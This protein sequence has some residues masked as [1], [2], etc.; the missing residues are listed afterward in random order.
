MP[1]GSDGECFEVVQRM[2]DAPLT[3]HPKTGNPVKKIFVAPNLPTRYNEGATKQKLSN[4][5]VEKHGFTKYEK[6]KVTGLYHKTAG[7]DRRAPDVVDAP[8]L[9]KMQ[10]KGIL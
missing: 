1:D 8:K 3:K 4:E 9:K 6:D 5:N 7:K 2:A 10:N